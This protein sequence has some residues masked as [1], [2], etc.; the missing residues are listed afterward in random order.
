MFSTRPFSLFYEDDAVAVLRSRRQACR[1]ERSRS[2]V[3][4]PAEYAVADAADDIVRVVRVLMIISTV[5]VGLGR[6]IA[7]FP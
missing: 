7:D 3:G 5:R 2:P 6:F 1:K 4:P